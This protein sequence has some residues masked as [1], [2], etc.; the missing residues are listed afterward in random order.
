M[1][2]KTDPTASIPPDFRSTCPIACVLDILGDKWTLLVIRDLFLGKHRYG[3]FAESPEGIPTNILANRLKR[4]EGEGIV[5]KVPYQSNPVRMEY[6]LTSK[7]ADLGRVLGAMRKW[8]EH[9]VAGVKSP[10]TFPK[11]EIRD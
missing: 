6:F 8:A 10:E 9:H 4:L 7:G 3:E 11:P 2:K 5:T 1:T